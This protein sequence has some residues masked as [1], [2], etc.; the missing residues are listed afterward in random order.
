LAV[1]EDKIGMAAVHAMGRQVAKAALQL[2]AGRIALE[3][4]GVEIES[5]AVYQEIET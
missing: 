4:A 1:K 5:R 3:A 2:K